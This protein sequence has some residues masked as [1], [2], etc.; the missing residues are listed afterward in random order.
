MNR[1]I[2]I[3]DISRELKVHHSTVS[4]ALR[5]DPKVKEDTRKRIQAYAKKHG[6]KTNMNALQLRGSVKNVIA[7]IVPNINHVFFSKIISVITN[8]AYKDGFIVSVFQTNESLEIEKQVLNSVILNNIA[9]VIASISMETSNVEHFRALKKYKIP[10][11]MFD[12][13]TDKIKVPKVESNNFEVVSEVV[14]N[15]YQ[16]GCRRIV[17]VTGP[18]KISV[19]KNRNK[20]YYHM[21]EKLGLPYASSC[22]PK[23]EFT[24][25]TGK[26]TAKKIFSKKIKPDAIICDSDV[27][28]TG[29][30]FQLKEM[31]IKVPEDVKIVSFGDNPVLNILTPNVSSIIQPMNEIANASYELLKNAIS[32][33]ENIQPIKQIFNANLIYR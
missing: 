31:Q 29:I 27:L 6:Y 11:V 30:L 10:L 26:E 14:K 22:T 19:F 28:M 12:R 17:H 5:N 9:G 8:L 3:K 15:L 24:I 2:T 20:G 4:R 7:V 21:I 33:K 13:V 18:K 25:E 23:K 32:E 16:D 1:R